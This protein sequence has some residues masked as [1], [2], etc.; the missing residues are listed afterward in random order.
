M[1]EPIEVMVPHVLIEPLR[2]W[3][4]QRGL[5]LARFPDEMQE[6]DSLEAY[7]ITPTDEAMRRMK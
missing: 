6:A 4:G 3:L 7:L 2:Q 1:D 5:L